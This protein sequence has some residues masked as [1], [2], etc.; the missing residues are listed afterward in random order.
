VSPELFVPATRVAAYF[1]KSSLPWYVAGGWAVDLFLGRQTRPHQD[2]EV[3]VL[4]RD[5]R[6]LRHVFDGW[7]WSKAVT[8]S[9]GSVR[10]AWGEQEWLELPIHELYAQNPK[11]EL[12]EV[13]L[14][15]CDAETWRFRRELTVSM[16]LSEMGLR[17]ELGIPILR[18]EIVLLHKAKSPRPKDEEDFIALLP[19]LGDRQAAWLGEALDR[20][21]PGHPWRARL[22]PRK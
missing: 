4:R 17:S 12:V 20:C 18:P 10:A 21:H 9:Q 11:G 22:E 14:Q 6:L 1:A 7:A 15:E 8:G 13:L 3:A 2:I 5:Q 19:V 16:P